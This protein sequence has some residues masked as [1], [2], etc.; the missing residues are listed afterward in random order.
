MKDQPEERES[1]ALHL[2]GSKP[3]ADADQQVET[4]VASAQ[5]AEFN[6]L[7]LSHFPDAVFIVQD[8]KIVFANSKM[9]E[10]HGARSVEQLIGMNAL[11]LIS[12]K[13]QAAILARHRDLAKGTLLGSFEHERRRLDGS[14][15]TARVRSAEAE[16]NGK[17][18]ILLMIRD[19]QFLTKHRDA[20]QESEKSYRDLAEL[21]PDGILVH[22]NGISV[23]ANASM[24]RILG[25]KH[26][27]EVIG[28]DS[29][30][31][32]PP[33]HREQIRAR[34]KLASAGENLELAETQ[35]IRID[36]SRTSVERAV[37]FITWR[38]RPSYLL[39]VR[40]INERLKI[41]KRNLELHTAKEIAERASQAKSEFLA[42]MS[43]EIRT[44]MNG[45][46]GMTGLLLKTGLA[47]KQAQFAARIKE[48]G[49]TMLGLLNNL[50]DVSKIEAGQVELEPANFFL[51]RV[52]DEIDAH[53]RSPATSK[54]LTYE[55]R[56]APQTPEE[57]IGDFGRIKQVLF[58]LISNAVKF[59]ATGGVRIDVSHSAP[60]GDRC[61]LRFEVRDTGI[62]IPPEKQEMVFNKFAQADSSTT[63]LF[64]GTGLGLAI[65]RELVGMMDGEIGA[66]SEPGKGSHFWFTVACR[67]TASKAIDFKSDGT[68]PA[69]LDP[70]G[71]MPPLRILLA[72]DNQINQEIAVACLEDAGHLVDLVE[73][74]ADAV[75]AVKKALY[76]LVL[77]DVHMPIMDGVA[78]TQEIRRLPG[79]RSKIPI[80]ALTAN[81]MVGDREKYILC[82]MDDY[83]S[84]PFNSD[85]LL[86]A[87]QSCIENYQPNTV[88]EGR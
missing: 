16:W 73:N 56:I 42:N 19:S 78:A 48:S 57:F 69:K 27:D 2:G 43:H 59:T 45:I 80:I 3:D 82:G 28:R 79:A 1:E 60:A 29:I 26:P 25:A 37:K 33:E 51:A 58:N 70:A 76:D 75:A 87:I 88:P 9:A 49:E 86:A 32:I 74:G 36:G 12:T 34:R 13:D 30:E 21:S 41:Q 68:S 55:T 44:P 15:F 61:L 84:K 20:M 6:A 4:G 7:I 39:L 17:K 52:L 83:A 67:E 50:L 71:K 46:L 40:D 35:Y 77:M 24:A 14:V 18:S 65:C 47:P 53:M 63:R 31:L 66:E 38:G 54:G 62:G 85:E 22:T 64:G 81:A 23:F 72:E 11:D 10:W 8:G 5:T